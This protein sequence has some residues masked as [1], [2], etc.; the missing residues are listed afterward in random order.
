MRKTCTAGEITTFKFDS[1]AEEY[2]VKNLPRAIFWSHTKMNLSNQKPQ[3]SNL[4]TA[5][6][7]IFVILIIRQKGLL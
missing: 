7:S 4:C 2:R 1:S 3:K 5:R 6:T